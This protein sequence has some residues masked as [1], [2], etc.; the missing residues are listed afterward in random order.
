[1]NIILSNKFYYPRGGDCTYTIGLEKLLKS[2]SHNVAIFTMNHPQNLKNEYHKF[3]LSYIDYSNLNFKNLK[4]TLLRPVYSKEVKI[5]FN[6]LIDNFKPDIIHLNNIHSQISPAIIEIS[7]KKGIPV[8]W[9]LHDYKL[10]CPAYTCLRN[11]IICELCFKNKLN[12]LKYKCIKN[13]YIASI[14]GYFEAIKWNKNYLQQYVNYFISPS[15]FLKNK[16]IEAG[17]SKDKI[18]VLNNF[19]DDEKYLN[20]DIQKEKYYC[21]FGRLS[22]EKGILTLLKAASNLKKFKLKIIGTGP[23]E[24]YLKDEY[25]NGNI[26]FLG[27]KPYEEFKD[28]IKNSLFTVVPSEWYENYSMSII[29]SFALKT[30]VIASN[31]GGNPE[32]ALNGK[33]GF[34]FSPGNQEELE[35]KIK[36]LFEHPEIAIQLGKNAFDFVKNNNNSQ[37]HYQNIIEIYKKVIS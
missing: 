3:W 9:T 24:K 16:M 13:S 17:Y 25:Q 8:L 33:T 21:Y 12:V 5:K 23:L 19:I 6:N 1:M 14:I 37:N 15:K 4:E 2:K 27:Y 11:N 34:L 20:E 31:I 36:Y 26:E 30:T 32:I 18:V 35:N 28:I 29:E 7:Y 22:K 10:I